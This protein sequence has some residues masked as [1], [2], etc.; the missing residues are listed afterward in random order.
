MGDR[1]CL[2]E[3]LYADFSFSSEETVG[4]GGDVRLAAGKDEGSL[5]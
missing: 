3:E 1:R 4:C 5:V 2:L